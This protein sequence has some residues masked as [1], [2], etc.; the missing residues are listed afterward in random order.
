[1]PIEMRRVV[2]S[3]TEFDEALT[4]FMAANETRFNRSTLIDATTITVDPLE[5]R[6]VMQAPDG[7]Q[8]NVVLSGSHLAAVLIKYCIDNGIPL[9]RQS[10][11]SVKKVA[12]GFALD[13]VIRDTLTKQKEN[14]A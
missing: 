13:T 6:V 5:V 14:V 3:E 2:L 12:A 11:K 8:A 10:A 9:P 1:M 4:A 7:Q